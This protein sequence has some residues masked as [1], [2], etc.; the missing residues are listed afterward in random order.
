MI[1]YLLIALLAALA[2][3]LTGSPLL[4]SFGLEAAP[5]V[6]ALLF[7]AAAA[8]GM[9]VATLLFRVSRRKL[10]FFFF[11]VAAGK[12]LSFLI[13][14]VLITF[15]ADSRG[16]GI[17]KQSAGLIAFF[18]LFFISGSIIYLLHL[19]SRLRNLRLD[20]FSAIASSGARED[21]GNSVYK[22]L[23]TSVI[24][25]G[26][27]AD[28]VETGFLDGILVA[29]QFVLLELQQIA[30]SSDPIKRSRGRRGL[31]ILNRMKRS[32]RCVI[33]ITDTDFPDIPEVDS[34]LIELCKQIGGYIITNDFNLN[35][36][37]ELQGVQILNINLLTNALKPS[38]LPGEEMRVQIIKEGKDPNQG[39]AY[40][41]DGT[42]IVVDNGR[43]YINK[44]INVVVTSVFQTPAGRMIFTEPS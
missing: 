37:A 35:K 4:H 24:I 2:G 33:K 29:P 42:M 32:D 19:E 18:D 16:A 9:G 28:I 8:A 23:D 39:V 25:D 3:Y 21:D 6:A 13:R 17:F 26:R 1:F 41:E 14:L 34:K 20:D 31:D 36:V 10:L 43:R 30:D 5:P 27:I 12:F 44:K 15:L 11:G 38:V 22:I 40:L 7:T